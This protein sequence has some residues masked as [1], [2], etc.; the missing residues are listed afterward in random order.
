MRDLAAPARRGLA[1]LG[2]ILLA[3]CWGGSV[4]AAPP[5]APL[6]HVFLI[7]LE[8]RGYASVIGNADMP[9][10]NAL[11]RR[12]GLATDSHGVA[13]PSLPNYVALITGDTWGSHSDAPSQRFDHPSLAGQL[14]AAGL[15]WKGYMQGL[16]SA[17]YTGDYAGQP[18]LYAKKHDP[19][20]LIPAIAGDPRRAR[21][22]VPLTQLGADLE[23][24]QAPTFA[25]IVP[26]LCHDMHGAPSCTGTQALDR[27]GDAFVDTWVHRIMT[28][29]AWSGHAAIVITFD[30]APEG[31]A[32]VLGLGANHIALIVITSDGPRGVRLSSRTDHY[33]LLRTLEDAWGLPRLGR[34][35]NA[36]SM[37]PLFR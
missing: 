14:E 10:I 11:A 18:V 36:G 24:G 23:T 15:S 6:D 27:A 9:T 37:A 28:S 7:V 35:Q 21:R 16:P 25:F 29:S 31:L 26:D 22:V 13:H 20:M 8:N 32:S 5:P 3:A 19:F 17:G 1:A 33:S 12:Y 4:L 34:A 2:A 30:E